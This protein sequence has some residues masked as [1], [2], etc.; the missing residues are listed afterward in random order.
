MF[1][2]KLFIL[3]IVMFV[4]YII[5]SHLLRVRNIVAADLIKEKHLVKI[6]VYQTKS[7]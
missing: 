2:L 5:F 3:E 1:V 4:F 6:G 7:K